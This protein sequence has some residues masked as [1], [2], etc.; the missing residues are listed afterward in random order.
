VRSADE[1][2]GPDSASPRQKAD[3][4]CIRRCGH[5][6]ESKF[7]RWVAIG[8]VVDIVITNLVVSVRC[9]VI[10]VCGLEIVRSP[11]LEPR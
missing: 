5:T 11:E 8:D 6:H 3:D 9:W 1:S 2:A 7:F 4:F 10:I